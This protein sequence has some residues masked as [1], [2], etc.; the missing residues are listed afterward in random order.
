MVSSSQEARRPR[1]MSL[2]DEP[3]DDISATQFVPQ[4]KTHE[5]QSSEELWE[6]RGILDERGG[7][8]SKGEYLLDWEDNP[9]TGEKYDPSWE[10]KIN[11]TDATIKEWKERIKEDPTLVGRYTDKGTLKKDF[12]PKTAKQ[13]ARASRKKTV[14]AEEDEEVFEP[15]TSR[16]VRAVSTSTTRSR[17]GS[18]PARSRAPAVRSAS[19]NKRRH[20]ATEEEASEGGDEAEQD[21]GNHRSISTRSGSGGKRQKRNEGAADENGEVS[22]V[23]PLT[24]TRPMRTFKRRPQRGTSASG[25]EQ[26]GADDATTSN[27]R[28]GPSKVLNKTSEPQNLIPDTDDEDD[29]AVPD[30]DEVP[31]TYLPQ[32]KATNRRGKQRA[33]EPESISS[34][35]EEEEEIDELNSSAPTAQIQGQ[36]KK[37]DKT[38]TFRSP[39]T[40]DKHS[41]TQHESSQHK[42]SERVPAIASG[43]ERQEQVDKHAP[44]EDEQQG[45][46]Q[47]ELDWPES[48]RHH[49]EA[50]LAMIL[51]EDEEEQ[52]QPEAGPSRQVPS[53]ADEM[54]A[55][56]E[57]A[58]G[59]AQDQAVVLT[60][61]VQVSR[62]AESRTPAATG[63]VSTTVRD[64]VF[65]V[66]AASPE[67]VMG[68]TQ[69]LIGRELG[70]VP[71][72]SPSAFRDLSRNEVPTQAETI[73]DFSSPTRPPGS[74]ENDGAAWTGSMADINGSHAPTEPREPSTGSAS[75]DED[76]E[77][78]TQAPLETQL[79]PQSQAV[80]DSQVEPHTQAPLTSQSVPST[81]A[82]PDGQ[83]EL[84]LT[85]SS[86]GTD[87]NLTQFAP[88]PQ[89]QLPSSSIPAAS[90]SQPASS[91]E[92]A[93]A[94]LA[95]LHE[96][97]EVQNAAN[98]EL[99][100]KLDA[101]NAEMARKDLEIAL[102]TERSTDLERSLESRAADADFMRAQYQEAS[103]RALE[104]AHRAN[105]LKDDNELLERQLRLGL[106]QRDK[107]NSALAQAKDAE[108]EQLQ[109]KLKFF[110]DRS[111]LARDNKVVA[112]ARHYA[113][114]RNELNAKSEELD[115]ALLE[116]DY[117]KRKHANLARKSRRESQMRLHPDSP[118]PDSDGE[119]SSASSAPM[120][121]DEDDLDH[122][123]PDDSEDDDD[124]V[125]LARE[126]QELQEEQQS[127]QVSHTETTN[128][129][130]SSG[131]HQESQASPVKDAVPTFTSG[132]IDLQ[133]YDPA[134]LE[135]DEEFMLCDWVPKGQDRPCEAAFQDAQVS[136]CGEAVVRLRR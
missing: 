60:T 67:R 113:T 32:K 14:K 105:T 65:L 5:S 124:D 129:A 42:E 130:Q 9:D 80:P 24:Q 99:Q 64:D 93:N 98:A 102:L 47:S 68:P 11:A 1:S 70:A 111:K 127:A 39:T 36:P 44:S 21:N 12:R 107:H 74:N 101:V 94:E 48:Q 3:E 62:P 118:G 131:T 77:P 35:E 8:G 6:V 66:G 79:E 2:E 13:Q 30:E 46:S 83:P 120:F 22:L 72:M 69:S 115:T 97:L 109:L 110:V 114:L 15:S 34:T 84:R 61:E 55:A 108:I 119:S 41:P 117:W 133:P 71:F 10:P 91:S 27:A 73:E 116:A 122:E 52:S 57:A 89:S 96:M 106:M 90:A 81:Q 33:Q 19:D 100:A 18:S 86:G 38:V 7:R 51:D 76:M 25:D 45:E 43:D 95:A 54:P 132:T 135:L 63:P 40:Q 20:D 136:D 85:I 50:A 126:L 123:V 53:Q 29:E 82:P 87:L 78:Q 16:P 92:S 28:A 58:A 37:Q 31:A 49:L 103:T 125:D 17:Q 134:N 26:A 4:K 59:R 75:D 56:S 88:P 23:V 112:T 104:H 128:P 121:S